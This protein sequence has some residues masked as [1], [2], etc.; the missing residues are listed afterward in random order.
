MFN[1]KHKVK[2]CLDYKMEMIHSSSIPGNVT[3]NMMN[4]KRT[5]PIISFRFLCINSKQ[6]LMDKR[7]FKLCM[8]YVY[9]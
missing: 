7:V 2:C 9:L 3:F 1:Y 5:I 6:I 8:Q 4:R